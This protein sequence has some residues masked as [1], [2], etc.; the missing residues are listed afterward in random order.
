MEGKE[1]RKVT[2]SEALGI[3]RKH[4]K[5]LKLAVDEICNILLPGDLTLLLLHFWRLIA[6]F[7]K[8]PLDGVSIFTHV[9]LSKLLSF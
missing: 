5:N 7:P 4:S 1:K 6:G 3:L 8:N 2:D 9:F